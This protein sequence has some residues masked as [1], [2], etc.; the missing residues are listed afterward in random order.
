[1]NGTQ[2]FDITRAWRKALSIA[3]VDNFHFHDLRHTCASYLAMN[4]VPLGTIAE[5]LGHKD[6]KMTQRYSHLSDAHIQGVVES[7]N[8]KIFGG[9]K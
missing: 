3:G 7:M 4:G 2:A 8:K 6:L 1:M 9:A 5:V